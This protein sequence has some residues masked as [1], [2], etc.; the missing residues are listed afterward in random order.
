MDEDT[1]AVNVDQYNQLN[2]TDHEAFAPFLTSFVKLLMP[3]LHR[4]M[5][6]L[7]PFL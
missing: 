7:I 5:E 4:T 1:V 3:S 2:R 6:S